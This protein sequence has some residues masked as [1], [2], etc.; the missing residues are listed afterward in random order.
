[1]WRCSSVRL[2]SRIAV[3]MVLMLGV[4]AAF[5][6]PTGAQELLPEQSAAKA[7]QVLQQVI[8]ALG[9]PAYLNVHDTECEG[10]IAQFGSNDELMDYIPFRVLWLLPDKNRTEYISK[11]EHT[12]VG[13]LMGS[14][15]MLI[16]HGGSMI[17][18]FNGNE[19]WL[20]DK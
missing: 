9:G 12:I 20:L 5:A 13:F 18:I 1:M 4:A 11:G 17:T 8:G 3:C 14:D 7:R 6:K 10:R 15:G 19:G 2:K 16:T